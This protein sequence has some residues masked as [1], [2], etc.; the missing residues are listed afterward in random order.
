MAVIFQCL[1]RSRVAK[2]EVI[3][4]LLFRKIRDG[5][6][7]ASNQDSDH[8]AS[9]IKSALRTIQMS[10]SRLEN[11]EVKRCLGTEALLNHFPELT[12]GYDYRQGV[13]FVLFGAANEH[14]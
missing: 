13:H 14:C 7:F 2:H 3:E 11:D 12:V 10:R 4:R 6:W 9:E 5:Q 1:K 8:K